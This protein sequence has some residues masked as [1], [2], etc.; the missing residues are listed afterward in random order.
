MKKIKIV[1]DWQSIEYDEIIDVRS[2][3]EFIEDHIPNSINL[4]VLN[5]SERSKVGK[6]YKQESR[7][8]AKIL[9]ASIVSKNISKFLAKDLKNKTSNWKC[10]IYCWR[11][12][13]R[14]RSL[15][16]VLNE[17]GYDVSILNGGY[18]NYRSKIVQ[19]LKDIFDY[20][21]IVIQG[22]TGSGKTKII[23]ELK[24]N[25]AQAIDLENLAHHRGSLLGK[26]N[27]NQPSQKSFESSLINILKSFNKS[28][29]IFV[30]SE[31]SK[32]GK[33]HLPQELWSHLRT[34]KRIFINVNIKER[35]KFLINDYK[36][37]I[38]NPILLKPFLK[39]I[40]RKE[41]NE[42]YT[43]CNGKIKQNQWKEFVETILINHYDPKYEFSHTKNLEKIIQTYELKKLSKKHIHELAKK[44]IH[45]IK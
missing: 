34:S 33:L 12:G 18:K 17:I 16:L 20:K 23:K 36:H 44:I 29:P 31:S 7:F 37:L 38:K 6:L 4:P 14:S 5:N 1:D 8:K 41:N 45:K 11:G 26:I 25:K 13:Q 30:E 42:F 9:G 28:C 43:F 32:I 39:S 10:L 40:N 35:T 2:A 21:F 19:D 27:E 15:A 24:F 3:S 22:K